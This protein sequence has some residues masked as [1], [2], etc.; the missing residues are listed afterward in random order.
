MIDPNCIELPE[1]HELRIERI[2]KGLYTVRNAYEGSYEYFK[3]RPIAVEVTSP[4]TETNQ[5]QPVTTKEED[6]VSKG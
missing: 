5:S 1:N 3:N 6:V 4:P 2:E